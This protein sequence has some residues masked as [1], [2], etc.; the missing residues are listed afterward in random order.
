MVLVSGHNL[1]PFFSLT[2]SEIGSPCKK[3]MRC[4][5]CC[6]NLPSKDDSAVS[7]SS[8]LTSVVVG[9]LGL[10]HRKLLCLLSRTP[11]LCNPSSRTNGCFL[12]LCSSA[13]PIRGQGF[14]K[15]WQLVARLSKIDWLLRCYSKG[16][17]TFRGA[18][19]ARMMVF[20][21]N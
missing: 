20:A 3:P 14:V 2:C 4:L 21:S 9:V 6:R 17:G 16:L 11:L 8:S 10:A 19:T 13:R 7:N 15:P 12:R 1:H 18:P 5:P